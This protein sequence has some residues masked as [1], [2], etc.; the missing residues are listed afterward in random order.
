MISSHC[1]V[2]IAGPWGFPWADMYA[3]FSYL[4][5]LVATT[6]LPT[7]GEE[8]ISKGNSARSITAKG[9]R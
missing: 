7:P 6:N 8:E 4:M 2:H 5:S 9:S 1:A 3:Q